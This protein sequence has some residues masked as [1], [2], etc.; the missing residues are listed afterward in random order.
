MTHSHLLTMDLEP[1]EPLGSV[2]FGPVS[3]QE[4]SISYYYERMTA[5]MSSYVPIQCLDIEAQTAIPFDLYV[6]LPRNQKIILYRR[7]GSILENDRL[8]NFASNNYTHFYIQKEH[9]REFVKYVALRFNTLLGLSNSPDQARLM[10]GVAKSVLTSTFRQ[11]NGKI[12]QVMMDNLNDI[13]GTIIESSLE[14]AVYLKAKKMFQRL[15]QLAEKGSDFQKHPINVT[16]LA[17]L[18]SFGIGYNNERILGDLAMAALL[19]DVGLSKLSTKIIQKAHDPMG[20]TIEER[21]QLRAHPELSVDVLKERDVEISDLTE[22]IISQH[23]EEFAGTGYPLGLRG[24][25]LN[26]LSQILRV[27][28]EMDNTFGKLA[29]ADDA[30]PGSIRKSLQDLF[31]QLHSNK[32]VEPGLLSRIR[33]LVGV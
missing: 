30:V 31:D 3:Y 22:I 17:V 8:Q 32:V 23:H 9:Y 25:N 12:A 21:L 6:N 29:S 11:D 33:Y 19:H 15:T 4:I 14:G 24:Y 1:A 20:L 26:E 13:T 5:E 2:N 27:S 28:D 16:S 18:I 10:S 7:S